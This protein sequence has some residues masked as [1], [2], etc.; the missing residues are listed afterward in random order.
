MP[1]ASLLEALRDLELG[2]EPGSAA[3]QLRGLEV[4]I[5]ALLV[6]G[7]T[8][9]Q[10]WAALAGRGLKLSFSGFKTSLHRMQKE[11]IGLQKASNRPETCP[12]CGGLLV[13]AEAGCKEGKAGVGT[14]VDSQLAVATKNDAPDISAP[15]GRMGES[16]ARRLQTGELQG[17]LSRQPT[18]QAETVPVPGVADKPR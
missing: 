2:E 5:N 18:V 6:Q 14:T 9:R 7:Y 16:F 15:D 13:D 10:I 4:E 11:A 1:K 17:G 3:A 8:Q 12:H